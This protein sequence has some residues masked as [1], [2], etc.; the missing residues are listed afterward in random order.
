MDKIKVLLISGQLTS[1]HNYPKMN[2]YIRTM[3]EATGR[4]SVKVIE[5]FNGATKRTVE[6][7]DLL[8]LN[9]D[10]KTLPTSQYKRWDT[11]AEDVF[12]EAVKAGKGL[13][14]HHSSV[15]LE[16]DMPD[17]YKEMWGIYLTTPQS[18]KNPCDDVNVKIELPDSPIMKGLSDYMVVG[19][20]F[21]AGVEYYPGTKAQV[22]SAVYDDIE[23]Y[24]RAGFPSPHHPVLVPEGKLENMRGVNTMQPV[25]WTNTYGAGRIFA[26]SLGHDIDTY[27]RINYLTTLV[28]GAQWA[29]TGEVTIDKPDRSGEKRFSQWPYY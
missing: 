13:F 29:A 11:G 7:Y 27:R 19:D 8:F 6:D 2:E 10:G 25:V 24:Q 20:D 17:R 12:F 18:R 26:C 14:I 4:F 9:Y 3:L 22:L 15:W 21:F 28:R 23:V 5:E 1:E 16:E